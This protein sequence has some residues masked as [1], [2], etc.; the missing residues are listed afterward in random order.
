MWEQLNIHLVN[1]IFTLFLSLLIGMEQRFRHHIKEKDTQLF[2]T[3]RTFA[4]IGIAG[5]VF[6][7]LNQSIPGIYLTAFVV[8][9]AL[10]AVYYFMRM[11][12]LHL[13]GA[14]SLL[15]AILTFTIGPVSY[16]YNKWLVVLIVTSILILIQIKKPLQQLVS[17]FSEKEFI[18]LA[19]FLII[20]AIILPLLPDQIIIPQ[21]PVSPFKFWLVIVLVSG[22]SYVSYLL[23]KFVFPRNSIWII[24]LL[25]GLYSSTATT[26]VLSR[27]SKQNEYPPKM[28]AAPI[29]LATGMMFLRVWILALILHPGLARLLSLPLLSL[30]LAD[31]LMVIPYYLKFKKQQTGTT[32]PSPF[33]RNPL[34]WKVAII[35]GVLFVAFIT[36]THYVVNRF[37]TT[38]LTE[39]A[40]L[41]G[42]V[43]I[44][45]FLVGIFTGQ[46][47]TSLQLLARIS[48]VS[49]GA[50]NIAKA[51]YTLLFGNK[52]LARFALPGFIILIILPFLWAYIWL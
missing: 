32:A 25:G 50:N 21:I 14:T 28:L 12:Q 30:L 27:L 51:I 7:L 20:S 40:F 8:L 35:F 52:T 9:G 3:D 2:G 23:K 29:W 33:S 11:K 10:L 48:L 44:D 38:G 47:D 15:V 1:F 19:E 37:G 31:L 6:Y 22:I 26:I 36:T 41:S 43:D 45:P 13:Y 24:A 49:I 16:L 46:Y 5:F 4:F 17:R 39:L 18:I 34:E 42:L